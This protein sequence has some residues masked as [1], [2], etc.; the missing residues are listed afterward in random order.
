MKFVPYIKIV[1]LIACVI[2]AIAGMASF[3]SEQPKLI[4]SAISFMLSFSFALIIITAAVAILMPI[5]GIVQNPKNSTKSLL[6]LAIIVVVFL[7]AYA[8]S[9]EE[10]I[11]VASGKMLDNA[12]ELKFS[13]TALY[14]TYFAFA[15]VIISIVFGEIYKLF[16]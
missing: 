4:T 9:S 13:D 15:G 11:K 12:W 2:V 6:G 1:L 8:M 3:D 10:P 5:V 16:K 14:A 7:V